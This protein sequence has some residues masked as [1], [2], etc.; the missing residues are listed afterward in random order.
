LG[1][2]GSTI[3]YHKSLLEVILFDVCINL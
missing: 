2:C 3:P 1:D